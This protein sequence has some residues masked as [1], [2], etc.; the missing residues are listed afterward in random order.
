MANTPCVH[1]VLNFTDFI[2]TN[3]ILKKDKEIKI[4]SIFSSTN[5]IPHLAIF[6]ASS[7]V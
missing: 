6:N 1:T 4:Y 2:V 7:S 3:F 5:D